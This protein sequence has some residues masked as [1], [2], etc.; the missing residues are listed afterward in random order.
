MIRPK[1]G[2]WK[3][4][5]I[6]CLLIPSSLSLS[7]WVGVGAMISCNF[8]RGAPKHENMTQNKVPLLGS[9]IL[10]VMWCF[11]QHKS[12]CCP[13]IWPSMIKLNRNLHISFPSIRKTGHFLSLLGE[14][15]SVVRSLHAILSWVFAKSSWSVQL[16]RMY[17]NF[18][19]KRAL[20]LTRAAPTL[21]P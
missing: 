14:S 4:K 8:L 15:Y 21:V 7:L 16:A 10:W 3:S 6:N 17:F 11:P 1:E 13:Q 9:V 20:V 12:W 5:N 19:K 2:G 18:L